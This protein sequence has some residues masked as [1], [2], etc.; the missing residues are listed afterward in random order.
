MSG[1]TGTGKGGEMRTSLTGDT[2]AAGSPRLSALLP[3]SSPP[4]AAHSSRAAA[5]SRGLD[6][7]RLRPI[8]S[9]RCAYDKAALPFSICYA[10]QPVL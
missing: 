8:A 9:S 7:C 1:S 2:G 4:S 3:R 10:I 6:A 5:S